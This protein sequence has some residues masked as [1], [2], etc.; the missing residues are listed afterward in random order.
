MDLTSTDV[1][2]YADTLLKDSFIRIYSEF[3]IT[4]FQ[5]LLQ[6]ANW[7]SVLDCLDANAA[8]TNFTDKFS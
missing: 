5:N 2:Y 3:N 1:L 6:T 4:K 7:S 8:Y